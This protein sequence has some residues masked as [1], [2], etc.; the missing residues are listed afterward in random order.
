VL[1]RLRRSLQRRVRGV[2]CSYVK[3]YAY[4][5]SRSLL[6]LHGIGICHRDLKPQNVLVDL[7]THLLVLCDFGSA[8]SLVPGEKNISY[9]SSRF[10][11]A[12]E[13]I[14]EATEYTCAIDVWSY[15]C[16]LGELLLGEYC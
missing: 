15:A 9:I 12:P 16:V 6:Y 10:Y 14:F 5:L 13:L 4:Q 7:D 1:L 3:L 11:R 8:K 2:R